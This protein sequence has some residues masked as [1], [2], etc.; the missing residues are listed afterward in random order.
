M[1]GRNKGIMIITLLIVLVV[2][3]F[4]IY[5]YR[6]KYVDLAALTIVMHN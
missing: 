6:C 3:A 5:M 2:R 4:W 1:L